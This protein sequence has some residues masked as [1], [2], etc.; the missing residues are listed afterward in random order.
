MISQMKTE[1][2]KTEKLHADCGVS[3][4]LADTS[5]RNCLTLHPLHRHHALNKHRHWVATQVLYISFPNCSI[6]QAPA[7]G[8]GS[9][10]A[11]RCAIVQPLA[12][13]VPARFIFE[14]LAR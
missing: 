10:V 7:P 1:E 4:K 14:P 9:T 6:R 8:K 12:K 2:N 5:F 13:R 11:A 3:L